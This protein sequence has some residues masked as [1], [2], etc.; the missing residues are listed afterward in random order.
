MEVIFVDLRVGWRGL[1][2]GAVVGVGTW[3]RLLN[4]FVS[5]PTVL[6]GKIV[7]DGRS[8]LRAS[9]EESG[10][11]GVRHNVLIHS[12]FKLFRLRLPLHR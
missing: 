8:M 7:L 6:A 5:A 3:C 4:W 2:E 11:H 12:C 9:K 1:S 10:A